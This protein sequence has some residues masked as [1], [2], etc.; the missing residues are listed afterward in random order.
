V[1]H[2]IPGLDVTAGDKYVNFQRVIVAPVNQGTNLPLDYS[3]TWTRNLPSVDVHY[4]LA[5]NW[6]AY[7]QYAKGFL[8]PNLNTLYVPNPNLNQLQPEGTTNIQLGTTWVGSGLTV[9]ADVYKINFSNLI[10]RQGGGA[11][12]FFYNLGGVKY[13]G[14]EAEATYIV[15]AGFSVYGNASSNSAHLTS[16]NTWVPETPSRTAALGVLYN[17]N[18]WQAS[19]IDKYVGTRFGDSGNAFR[20]SAYSTADA[21]VNYVVGPLGSALKNGKIGV[22]V[23][24]IADHRSIYFQNGYSNANNPLFFTLPGRSFQVNLSASF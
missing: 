11:N 4:K 17:Q 7:A 5:D 22:T 2:V 13:K 3:K 24:N 10:Q 15:G 21:A 8:A 20:L 19:L 6:A 23:Q 16:D 12:S 1:W 9:S 18:A 14:A